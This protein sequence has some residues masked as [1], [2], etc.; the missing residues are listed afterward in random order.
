MEFAA[1]TTELAENIWIAASDGD[2]QQVQS[3][4]EQGVN[5]NAQDEFGYS[6]L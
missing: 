5:I 3:F 6:P 4:L 1:A 2:I